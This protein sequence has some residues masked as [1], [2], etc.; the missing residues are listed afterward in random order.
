MTHRGKNYAGVIK[1]SLGWCGVVKGTLGV[2]RILVGFDNKKSLLNEIKKCFTDVDFESQFVHD[3]L[4][5]I[6]DYI[7]LRTKSI[8]INLDYS[9]ST[10]FDRMVYRTL[11]HVPYGT[12]ITYKNLAKMCGS[13]SYARA[14]ARAL[15]RNPFPLAV[16]CHR[17]IRSDGGLGGFSARGG[18]KLKRKLIEME[19]S[20]LRNSFQRVKPPNR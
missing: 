5:S 9:T 12:T 19:K 11:Y 4:N 13:A 20:F 18:V 14:V 16:P 6:D 8:I 3:D 10:A 7:N 2:K 17:V 1:T 15:A